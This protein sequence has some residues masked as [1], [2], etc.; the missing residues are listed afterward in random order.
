[1]GKAR[2][3][4]EIGKKERRYGKG[5][6]KKNWQSLAS[7]DPEPPLMAFHPYTE[8]FCGE[9][10]SP[11]AGLLRLHGKIGQTSPFSEDAQ[12]VAMG[13]RMLWVPGTMVSSGSGCQSVKGFTTRPFLFWPY[14][15]CCHSKAQPL[16][17]PTEISAAL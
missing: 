14:N 9:M 11:T 10:S 6:S 16:A 2:R 13:C 4:G 15:I 17:M 12:V 7:L 8:A 3:V 1:M 5:G